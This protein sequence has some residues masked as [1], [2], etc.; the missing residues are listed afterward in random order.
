MEEQS[1]LRNMQRLLRI[2][3]MRPVYLVLPALLSMAGAFFEGMGVVLLVPI[4][5]GLFNRDFSFIRTSPR[6]LQALSLLPA[7][8]SASD[9]NVLVLILATFVIVIILKNVLRY[10]SMLSMCFIAYRTAHHLRKQ[11]FSRY[12]TFGK[13]FFDRSTIGHHNAVLSHF[14]ELAM[15]PVIGFDRYLSQIF[16]LLTYF[17]VMCTI[18][19]RLTLFALPLFFILHYSVSA[20]I[21]RIR[22]ISAKIANATKS[23]QKKSIETLTMIPVVT[24]YNAQP[25]ERERYKKLSDDLSNQWFR[26]SMFFNLVNPINELETLVAMMALFTVILVLIP[27][28]ALPASAMI[29]YFYLV[30]NSAVKFGTLTGLRSQIATASGPVSEILKVFDEEQSFI[31][32]SGETTF[33]G[34]QSAIEFKHFHY[35]YPGGRSVLSDISFLVEKGKMTAIVGPTGSGKSTLV[36]ILMR[37]YDC[38]PASLFIDQ[39]DIRD[40]TLE[41]IRSHMALVSQ[42]TLLFNDTIRNNIAYGLPHV[43]EKEVWKAVEEAELADF[44]KKLPQGLDT[45]VGDRGVQL[46]GGEKQR[47]SIA[48]ALLKGADILMLDEATS[49]LDSQTESLIQSAIDRVTRDKTSIVI[50][51]RLS[52]IKHADTIVV[53]EHGKCVETGT[54]E[55]LLARKGVFHALWEAQKFS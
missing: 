25:L 10:A 45:V 7:S 13:F 52:T 49:S 33:K 2:A 1:N 14:T 30:M 53:I 47:V 23:L 36:H 19:W 15:N 48:R 43:S 4:V 40:Y 44:V 32:P 42:D 46:S 35:A 24:A 16:S 51:H 17:V 5:Q 18:S 26:N 38:E 34:L 54:L 3:G 22:S 31:V 12:L 37:F 6:A 27:S 39:L 11:I 9:H 55:E 20:V 50:A 21:R 8:W 28:S 41:S 29:V